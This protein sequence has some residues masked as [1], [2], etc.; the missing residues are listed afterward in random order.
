MKNLVIFTTFVILSSTY[1]SFSQKINLEFENRNRE[2]F[3]NY[4]DLLFRIDDSVKV[5]KKN[6]FVLAKVEEFSKI[7]S[8]N[9]RV[10]IK[11]N[12][13]FEFIKFAAYE[14]DFLERVNKILDK[15]LLEDRR[16]PLN[17]L[18]E[19][20]I[21]LSDFFSGEGFP[22]VKINITYSEIKNLKTILGNLEIVSNEPRK[23][24]DY[25]VKGYEKF[26]EKFID[27][28]LGVKI[29]EKLDVKKLKNSTNYINSLQFV[30][31]NKEPEILFTKDSS[32]VYLYFEQLKQNNFDG[33]LS[34]SSG[35]S[36]SKMS[37]DGYLKLFLLNSLN[38]GETIKIDYNSVNDG[39]K[40]LK[41]N[42]KLPYFFNSDFSIE[43]NLNIT[44]N[45]SIFT[46]SNFSFKTGL[47]KRKFSN[48]LGLNVEN[49]TSG[50]S[51]NLYKNFKSV[52]F[53]YELNYQ[54]FNLDVN[55]GDKTFSISAKFSTG[56]KKQ[57]N[58]RFTKNNFDLNIFKKTELFKRTSLFSN[59]RYENLVSQNLV[60]NEMIRFGGAESIRGF[61]DESILT[62]EYFLLRNNVN[63]LL[64][65]N[66][67][68]L[69][70]IDYA[71]YNNDILNSKNNIYSLGLGFE[72]LNN[73]NLVSVNYASGSDFD[74]KFTFK[75][76][77]LSINFISFF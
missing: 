54:L 53:F 76:A 62:N 56:H 5:L 60:N 1:F 20:L 65:E 71:N 4:E 47:E 21:N 14:G 3:D 58:D 30:K 70:I 55:N 69:G 28:F 44:Q 72:F 18:N 45:D 38:Y 22:F 31:Q 77:R 48:Y 32:I 66:F 15:Y 12:S 35:E 6:G 40:I 36:D 8:L 23:I 74:Q 39:L 33:L 50:Y 49:S 19:L 11:K 51:N 73:K 43:S 25:I 52:Q 2:L 7:D 75:N 9:Y 42:F 13:Q 57:L 63:I 59:A 26:P 17:S 16:I 37:I 61:I 10:K 64:N 24:D 68:L 46:N 41:T 27:K 34:L 67:S 29:G